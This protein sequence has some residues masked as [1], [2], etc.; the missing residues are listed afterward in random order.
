MISSGVIPPPDKSSSAVSHLIDF[1]NA[2]R[3][4]N[5]PAD[6]SRPEYRVPCGNLPPRYNICPIDPVDLVTERDGSREPPHEV[7]SRA[8]MVA[9]APQ[10]IEGGHVQRA[11]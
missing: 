3:L 8:V 10:G 4:R 11:R 2:T 9:E 5:T 1:A 7:G 6:I